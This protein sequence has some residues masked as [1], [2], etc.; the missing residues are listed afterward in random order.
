MA[1]RI[2]DGKSLAA[3]VRAAVKREVEALSQRGIRPGLAVVLAGD[4]P[5]SRVYV[6]NKVRACEETGVR[7]KLVELPASISQAALLRAVHE[8]NADASVHGILI[9]LPL[10]KQIDAARVLEAV[11]PAKDVDGFHPLS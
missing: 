6:R 9:Q 1:A 3:Q 5:A 8:L 7:S 11:S 2:L 10:P 4:N